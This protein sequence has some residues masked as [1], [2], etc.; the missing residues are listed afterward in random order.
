MLIAYI[1]A[2]IC[3][4]KA[5]KCEFLTKIVPKNNLKKFLKNKKNLLYF[6]PRIEYN[7]RVIKRKTQGLPLG[8]LK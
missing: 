3:R 1:F 8:Y 4:K 2:E 7:M 5:K 6:F